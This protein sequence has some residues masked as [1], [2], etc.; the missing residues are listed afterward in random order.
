[1]LRPFGC[2]ITNINVIRIIIDASASISYGPIVQAIEMKNVGQS[3]PH[4]SL[5]DFLDLKPPSN[6]AILGVSNNGEV[7][8]G[9]AG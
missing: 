7:T 8:D 5:I 4:S 9:E 1:M 6:I 3:I 2:Q